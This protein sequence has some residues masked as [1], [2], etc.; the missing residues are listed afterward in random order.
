MVIRPP[1]SA[2]RCLDHRERAEPPARLSLVGGDRNRAQRFTGHRLPPL[3]LGR[4]AAIEQAGSHLGHRL[5]GTLPAHPARAQGLIGPK[6]EE[7]ADQLDRLRALAA[8]FEGSSNQRRDRCALRLFPLAHPG[9]LALAHVDLKVWPAALVEGEELTRDPLEALAGSP[10]VTDD[11]AGG[12]WPR[13]ARTL[14]YERA[15]GRKQ[16]VQGGE[17]PVD[18]RYRDVRLLRDVLPRR[19]EYAAL[20]MELRRCL[21]YP[22]PGG[23]P[24]RMRGSTCHMNAES[25]N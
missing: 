12:L 23:R 1:V 5:G 9:K 3:G 17:V 15:A 21:N 6:V 8:P 14:H 4:P 10:R 7:R 11:R 16:L 18:R 19:A 20:A 13:G 2:A 24:S 25:F 22:L